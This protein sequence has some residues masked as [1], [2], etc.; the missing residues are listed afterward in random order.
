MTSIITPQNLLLMAPN[1]GSK[2]AVYTGILNHHM[3]LFSINT[4]K[5]VA[6]FLG[7]LLVESDDLTS[8]REGMFYRTPERLMQVWPS[9]FPTLEFAKQY[10]E[11]PQKLANYV[12]SNR[13]GNGGP[14]S[15]DGWNMRGTGWIQLTGRDNITNFAKYINQTPEEAALYMGTAQGAAQSACW[16]W[17]KNGINRL[18]DFGSLD[19]VSDAVNLGRQT[20]KVGDAEG[21]QKRL[22]KTELCKKILKV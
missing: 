1:V 5:R 10:V 16:F 9:R 22:I 7:Q 14:E 20:K 21:Y 13:M 15:N 6:M 8:F 2:S 3:D 4:P 19:A 12:Y 11:N 18:A 17:D